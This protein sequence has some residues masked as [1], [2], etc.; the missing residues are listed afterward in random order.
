VTPS[1][2]HPSKDD[3]DRWLVLLSLKKLWQ[4]AS[5]A[6]MRDEGEGSRQRA[7][8]DSAADHSAHAAA[9]ALASLALGARLPHGL[10]GSRGIWASSASAGSATAVGPTGAP[11]ADGPDQT[12]PTR[13]HRSPRRKARTWGGGRPGDR[14]NAKSKS[15]GRGEIKDSRKVN[16]PTGDGVGAGAAAE[17]TTTDTSGASPAV[18]YSTVPYHTV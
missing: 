11:P 17:L 2:V 16:R 4:S 12:V 18:Q 5:A 10:Q 8:S 13:P 15:G 6:V 14:P 3:Q 1:A 9:P 7:S